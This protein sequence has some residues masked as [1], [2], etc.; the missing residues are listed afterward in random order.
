MKRKLIEI[1]F[2]EN[3]IKYTKLCGFLFCHNFI[4]CFN[5][6]SF[7][8]VYLYIYVSQSGI[9]KK[10][11]MVII[12][13]FLVY[14]IYFLNLP[15]IKILKPFYRT[16]YLELLWPEIL[17]IGNLTKSLKIETGTVLCLCLYRFLIADL[18]AGE[19]Y[20]FCGSSCGCCCCHL[21]HNSYYV[22]H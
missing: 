15:K 19:F 13:H 17:S 10:T 20:C 2:I 8:S 11:T 18:V 3:K 7:R 21:H 22:W 12:D 6:F 5:C 14:L 9:L 4:C 16:K 1:E